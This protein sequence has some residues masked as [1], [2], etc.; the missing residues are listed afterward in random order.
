MY[1]DQL[2]PIT[3]IATVMGGELISSNVLMLTVGSCRRNAAVSVLYETDTEVQVKVVDSAIPYGSVLACAESVEVQ[4]QEPLGDRTVVDL[5]TRQTVVVRGG[6]SILEAVL[7]YSDRLAL[8]VDSCNGDPE[9]RR[10]TETDVD[11]QMWVVAPTS[12]F[13]AREDCRDVV[14]T[15]VHEPL[16]NRTVVD[17][18]S[19]QPVS[20]AFGPNSAF[21]APEEDGNL[22]DVAPPGINDPPNEAELQDLQAV[23]DQYGI[24]LQDA[25]DLYALN[26]NVTLSISKIRDTFPAAFSGAAI[27]DGDHVWIAFAGSAPEAALAMID[28]FSGQNG[29]SFEVR[30]GLGFTEV[31]L[32]A[33]IPAAHFAV[34]ESPDVR[35][36]STGYDY[37]TGEITT[38]VVLE[39]GAGESAVDDLRAAGANAITEATR[40][41]FLDSITYLVI[42]SSAAALG[43]DD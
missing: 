40:A 25:I 30:T 10:R 12:N 4:L 35:D 13:G 21:L 22:P 31:E 24:S 8:H 39:R 11:V 3:Q 19:G 43:A 34:Y 20:V 16:G 23:A 18:H 33:A 15:H 17:L 9:L 32:Q 42:R 38:V 27:V 41:D 6:V 26:D 28:A 1:T 5:S 2:V 29:V 14:E 37:S 7:L 36:A